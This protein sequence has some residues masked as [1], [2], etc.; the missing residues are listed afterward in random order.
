VGF[1]SSLLG[2]GGGIIHVPALVYLLGF[3][4]HIA[5]ATSHFILAVMS[6]TGTA[7]HIA[8]G[9]FAPGALRAVLLGAGALAGAQVGARVSKRVHGKW[10]LRSL[11]VGLMFVGLR[12]LLLAI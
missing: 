10:I 11:A 6:L 12:I 7:V 8:T 3:P 5:T 1:V 9:A 2:I 4:A